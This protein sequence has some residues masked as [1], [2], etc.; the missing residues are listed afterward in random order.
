[1]AR[2]AAVDRLPQD[3]RDELTARLVENGFSD[4]VALSEWITEKGYAISKTSLHRFGSDLEA[5]FEAAMQDAR[6]SIELAR[7]MRASGNADDDG[8][9]LDAASSVLQDQLLRISLALRTVDVDP[10]EAVKLVS[11]AS[12]ALADLGR[13]TVTNKKFQAEV[14]AQLVV[15][16]AE[17]AQ[18]AEKI[19]NQSGLTSGQAEQIRALIL[20]IKIDG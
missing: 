9:L 6:R 18:K 13:M 2:R 16:T 1:M 11:Q 17:A 12:R 8:T 3:I 7:A 14:R 5:Q 19:V 20:G 15:K 4:Y 10:A